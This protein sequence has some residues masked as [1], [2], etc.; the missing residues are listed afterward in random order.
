MSDATRAPS[1]ESSMMAPIPQNTKSSQLFPDFS[2]SFLRS[3]AR[4]G[5]R[6]I[7]VDCGKSFLSSAHEWFPKKGFRKID[8]LVRVSFDHALSS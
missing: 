1:Y 8:A 2:P 3:H 5:S 4:C 6:T 7:L